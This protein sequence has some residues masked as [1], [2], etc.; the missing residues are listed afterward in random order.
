MDFFTALVSGDTGSAYQPSLDIA[1]LFQVQHGPGH[2]GTM[3]ERGG[4][5][6]RARA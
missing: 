2:S 1:A 6:L 4:G 5:R 3:C